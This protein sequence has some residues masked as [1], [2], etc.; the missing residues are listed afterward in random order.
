MSRIRENR[1]W[2]CRACRDVT[3]EPALLTAPSPFCDTYELTAC[4]ECKCC[5]E[6]FA[7]ICDEPGCNAESGCGWPTGNEADAWGGYRNTCYKHSKPVA[8]QDVGR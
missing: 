4:P 1:L 2:R 5:D 3:L 6:G 7:P 8:A